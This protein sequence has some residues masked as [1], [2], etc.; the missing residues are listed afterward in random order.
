M[1]YLLIRHRVADFSTWKKAYDAHAND[2]TAAGLKEKEV[3]RD[4]NDSNQVIILFE[5][6]DVDKAKE[7]SKSPALQE[8]M[9]NAGVTDQPDLYFLER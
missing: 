2:R 8:A 3:L 5:V 7:F 9:R 4:L 6:S 1:T